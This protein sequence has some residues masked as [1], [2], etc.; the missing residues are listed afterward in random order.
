MKKQKLSELAKKKGFFAI[1]LS[2]VFVVVTV[3]LI[4]L[5]LNSGEKKENL[6]DLDENPIL[7]EENSENQVADSEQGTYAGDEGITGQ[8]KENQTQNE[9]ASNEQNQTANAEE[10]TKVSEQTTEVGQTDAVAG[11]EPAA[12][13]EVSVPVMNATLESLSFSVEDG[14]QWPLRGNIILTYSD[15]HAIYHPTLMQFKTNPAI[16][17]QGA[18]GEEV[19]AAARGII[20]NIEENVQTGLTVTMAIGNN[21]HLVYGQLADTGLKVGDLIER[22]QVL[23]TLAKVTK[24][25]TVEGEHLYFQVFEGEKTVNP[26]LLI[27]DE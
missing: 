26:M 13:E 18:Q 20:T 11:V 27:K 21:Y 7:T 22:G 14:L 24:Y 23:G 5:N 6:V 2:A 12:E 19:V 8:A 9:T 10:N 4:S 17:I 1:L 16:L 15:D 25:Y 3:M